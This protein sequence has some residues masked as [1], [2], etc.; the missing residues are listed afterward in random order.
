MRIGIDARPLVYPQTGIGR[1]T[2]EIVQRLLNTEHQLCL[3]MHTPA[4]QPWL[5]QA[6]LVRSGNV[7]SAALSTAFA[8]LAFP[9]WAVADDVQVFWSP[10]HH[11]PLALAWGS[12][13][14]VVTVHDLVWRKAGESMRPMARFLEATL[15]PPSVRAARRV[16]VPSQSTAA[17]LQAMNAGF[18]SKITITPLASHFA[19]EAAAPRPRSGNILFV[20]TF[21]PRKNISLLVEAFTDC[22]EQAHLDLTLHLAGHHGWKFDINQAVESSPAAARIMVHTPENDD[23]LA[24]L[25]RNCD[26]LVLPSWYEG[27]GLPV[28]EA[29]SFG[30]PVICSNISSMAEIVGPAGL[31]VEPGS[32]T[33]L[34]D[35]IHRL[36]S[37]DALY[38]ELS[39]AASERSTAFTWRDTARRTLQVLE[40]T[41]R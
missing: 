28:V 32:R 31:L 9:F 23:A 17:D 7:R 16:L 39:G 15:M 35:A 5:E 19:C 40:Q 8:Q 29:M 13:P 11:L 30:K 22:L 2:S 12:T 38:A 34:A 1:Y 41:A 24:K 6:H 37:D 4:N 20:G 27:F 25:Y 18:A 14:C 3:Y 36:A 33:A 21:E 26:F 10:R